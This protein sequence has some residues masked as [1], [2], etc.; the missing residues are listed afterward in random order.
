MAP[1]DRRVIGASYGCKSSC[2]GPYRPSRSQ[3]RRNSIHMI[4]DEI[5]RQFGEL[6]M[7]FLETLHR[8]GDDRN[9]DPIIDQWEALEE[10]IGRNV[11]YDEILSWFSKPIFEQP[12]T[13]H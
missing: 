5:K 1:G 7:N 13:L 6:S 11:C 12:V 4:T 10:K 2:A 9:L 3:L 8:D